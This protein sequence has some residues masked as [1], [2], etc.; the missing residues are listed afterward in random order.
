MIFTRFSDKVKVYAMW[1]NGTIST[2]SYYSKKIAGNEMVTIDQIYQ[3][4]KV[5]RSLFS[6]SLTVKAMFRRCIFRLRIHAVI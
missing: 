6:I 4:G 3:E 5:R 2:S 1:G